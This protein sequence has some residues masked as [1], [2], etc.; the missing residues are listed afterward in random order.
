[1]DNRKAE[2]IETLLPKDTNGYG[3]IFGGVIMSIMDKTAGVACWRYS[4]KRVVTKCAQEICFHTPVNMG[5]VVYSRAAI[6]HVGRSSMEVEVEVEA[7]N[8]MD[9]TIRRAASGIFT[10][11]ALDENWHPTPVPVWQPVTE[12]DI[13]KWQAAE[14]RRKRRSHE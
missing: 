13:E 1:M 14:L 10:M 4:R 12:T 3:N 9:G 11:V 6:V 5:E 8:V 2:L 7:E